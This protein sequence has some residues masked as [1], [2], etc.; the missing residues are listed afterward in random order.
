MHFYD[1][2]KFKDVMQEKAHI[3]FRLLNEMYKVK[4]E[5]RL[6]DISVAVVPHLSKGD[7]SSIIDGYKKASEDITDKFREVMDNEGDIKKIFN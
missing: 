1:G 2:Y 4:A 5:E 6:E 3:F 7:A